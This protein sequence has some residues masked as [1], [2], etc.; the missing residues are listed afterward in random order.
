MV[1]I[2]R[3]VRY[4][5]RD[6][7]VFQISD[8][9]LKEF[10]EQFRVRVIEAKRG[11]EGGYYVGLRY[12]YRE[13]YYDAIVDF[14]RQHYVPP[15]IQLS[16]FRANR[17]LSNAWETEVWQEKVKD[18]IKGA[19]R[20]Q[21]Y[22]IQERPFGGAVDVVPPKPSLEV[23]N[24]KVYW[25]IQY[26]V[27]VY[28]DL[29][30]QLWTSTNYWFFLDDVPK[31]LREITKVFG[32]YSD[33]IKQVR[34]FVTKN[35]EQ[36]F[37]LLK[38]FVKRIGS[39]DACE[40]IHFI[41]RPL[42][43]DELGMET[44]FWIHDSEVSFKGSGKYQTTVPQFLVDQETGFYKQIDN[45]MVVVMLP[46]PDSSSLIPK[47]DWDGLVERIKKIVFDFMPDVSV[48]VYPVSFA[49]GQ[50]LTDLTDQLKSIIDVNLDRRVLCLLPTP[51]A[52]AQKSSDQE[53]VIASQF[54]NRL[55][56]E[57]RKIYRN[58]YTV[59]LDWAGL[60]QD[61]REAGYILENA[62][63]AG[64]YRLGAQPWLIQNMPVEEVEAPNN[65][66]LGLSGTEKDVVP[67][68]AGVLF[69]SEGRFLAF[70]G[71]LLQDAK[72]SFNQ[73]VRR[74]VSNF[75]K[76]GVDR[77]TQPIPMQFTVHITPELADFKDEIK[78]ALAEE[79]ITCDIVSIHPDSPVRFFQPDNIQG[80]PSNGIALGNDRSGSAYLMNTLSVGEKTKQGYIYPSPAPVRIK[81]V[82]GYATLRTL[83]AHVYWFSMAD[84][85][86]FH[87]TVN[88]P[89]TV[90]YAQKLHKHISKRQRQMKVTRYS[91]DRTL[92]WL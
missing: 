10:H 74:L 41:E 8:D 76:W 82:T 54:F 66:F 27:V 80:T 71:D 88:I 56:K 37:T 87:R 64:F 85:N 21:G 45:A 57:I 38:R 63:L 81:R 69:D 92:F 34:G 11:F 33:V 7:F 59:S 83:A 3:P 28:K 36:L 2:Y 6:T 61:S 29:T 17:S 5:D 30:P 89:I 32:E 78:A 46:D 50:D 86:A 90:G 25:G 9:E 15:K 40:G 79:N 23:E 18:A 31:N 35:S 43:A 52:Q 53:L 39:L 75:A 47:I 55:N 70:G 72:R 42:S 68:V 19:M 14:F 44:W 77:K 22:S 67:V 13:K 4:P 60:T 12:D 91:S 24:V 20:S 84:V 26:R 73:V 16:V 65:Y 49:V 48:P 1:N 58:S 62:L 51:G